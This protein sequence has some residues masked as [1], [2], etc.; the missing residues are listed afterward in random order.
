MGRSIGT[1]PATWLA[2]N[3]TIGALVLVS[4]F[5]SLRGVVKHVVGSFAQHLIKER[6]VNVEN[7]SRV[8]CPTF[9]LHGKMD[10]LI[11]YSHS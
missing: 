10:A 11:P 2:A 7:I 5:T 4:G 6:F 9:I 8:I 3:K 1:G